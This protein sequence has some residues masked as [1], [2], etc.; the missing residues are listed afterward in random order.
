MIGSPTADFRAPEFSL[1]LLHKSSPRSSDFIGLRR[2]L[3]TEAGIPESDHAEQNNAE[4][5]DENV[6][7]APSGIVRH[8]TLWL[9]PVLV[10]QFEFLEWT[11]DNQLRHS[12]FV[13]LR[14]DRKPR[15]VAR[16]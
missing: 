14:E 13:S 4:L 3:L 11:P 1:Q 10:G 5:T 16:D 15:D 12:K 7:N 6:R 8:S 2:K 9:K